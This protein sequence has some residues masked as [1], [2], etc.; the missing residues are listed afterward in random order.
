MAGIN[1]VV[2]RLVADMKE[3]QAK[4][5]E[6]G[7][8]VKEF[9]KEA[10][11]M[12]GKWKAIGSKLST[13]V[14]MGV[15]GALVYGTEQAYKFNESLDAIVN[16]SG[17]TVEEVDKLRGKIIEVS[18]ATGYS[19]DSLSGAALQIEK[20]GFRGKAAYDLLSNAAMAAR[21]TGGQVADVTKTIIGVQTLQIAK[22]ESVAQITATLVEA[23]KMH[24]GSLD[25]LTT[26]LTG[27]VGAA[28]SAYG[29]N[30]NEAAAVAG[31]ASKAGI[32]NARSMVSLANSLGAIQNPTK[33]QD[34]ALKSLGLSSANLTKEMHRPDGLI[35]VMKTLAETAQRTGKPVSEVAAAVF[36]KAGAGTATVLINNI[37]GLSS[38]Y[39]TLAGSNPTTLQAQ[40]QETMKQLGPQLQTAGTNLNNALLNVGQAILPAVSKIAGWVASFA[41]AINSNATLRQVLGG[42]LFAG[43]VL[44]VAVKLKS[45]FDAVKG[46]F[47][48]G[49]QAANTVATDANTAALEANT[50]ALGGE[51]VVGGGTSLASDAGL[52]SKFG[53][54]IGVAVAAI[55]LKQGIVDP[56]KG[57]LANPQASGLEPSVPSG[58]SLGPHKPGMVLEV[59]DNGGGLQPTVSEKWVTKAQYAKDMAAQM[60]AANAQT[61]GDSGLAV[62]DSIANLPMSQESS[63]D[64]LITQFTQFQA[65]TQKDQSLS[66]VQKNFAA[67][68]NQYIGKGHTMAQWQSGQAQLSYTTGSNGTVTVKVN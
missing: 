61:L 9:G 25:S 17:A 41:G 59:T 68:M 44:S 42:T 2:V 30:L 45:A 1:E 10:D 23:N 49:A 29:V 39:K 46:L 56:T 31:I 66:Q 26:A 40:F 51:S 60:A 64:K 54:A 67:L 6:A 15:G 63:V 38:A 5:G 27:K 32:T 37:K 16:Q 48:G 43:V 22:G 19:A 57:A 53:P 12:G 33:A 36:G 21:I 65:K 47:T 11:T 52:A 55:A 4:M 7:H 34:L 50:I 35:E 13:G 58:G 62:P 24:L 8:T 28:L 20:A 14:L 18:N 3:F